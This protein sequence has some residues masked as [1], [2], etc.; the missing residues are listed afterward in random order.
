MLTW[1]A[2]A[3]LLPSIAVHPKLE[4]CKGERRDEPSV[5]QT[6]YYLLYI[7]SDGASLGGLMRA[8]HAC[9]R[10]LTLRAFL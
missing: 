2:K 4:A 9:G 5:L 10:I 8:H 1:V 3:G 6:S 7:G